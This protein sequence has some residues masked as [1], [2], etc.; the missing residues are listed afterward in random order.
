MRVTRAYN[1]VQ[2]GHSASHLEYG[3]A[4]PHGTKFAT[5]FTGVFRAFQLLKVVW[6]R[7]FIV[8]ATKVSRIAFVY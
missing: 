1:P 2:M 6:H 7:T 3:K 8:V 5:K 4:E